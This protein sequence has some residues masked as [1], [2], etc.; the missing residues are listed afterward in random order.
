MIAPYAK[1]LDELHRETQT[2][3]GPLGEEEIN[4]RI[5]GLQNTVGIVL[6]HMAGSE[7]FWIGEVV[8]GIPAHRNRDAEF[9]G[10][11][12]DKAAVLADLERAASTTRQVLSGLRAAD[13]VTDVEVRRAQGTVR[14]PRGQALLHATQHLA[15]HLGQLRLLAKLAQA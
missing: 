8:G 10:D 15:Y 13:L 14:E 4:R 6:R 5:A 2:I 12:I 3:V 9:A 1:V 7:R 11:R